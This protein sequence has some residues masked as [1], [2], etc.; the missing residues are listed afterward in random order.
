MQLESVEKD[1]VRYVLKSSIEASPSFK[2][3]EEIEALDVEIKVLSE[4]LERLIYERK[5]LA[6]EKALESY[7]A[8]KYN[9][10]DISA[11]VSLVR[12]CATQNLTPSNVKEIDALHQTIAP[13][14]KANRR[15]VLSR[16]FGR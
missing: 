15:G 3:S 9:T 16:L 7:I 11:Q 5:Q 1:G 10:L 4:E 2:E 12:L 14:L 13:A 8:A 6:N